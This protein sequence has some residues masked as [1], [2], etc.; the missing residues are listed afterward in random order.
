MKREMVK[1]Y[2]CLQ[3]YSFHLVTHS[4]LEYLDRYDIYQSMISKISKIS[5]F[6]STV[7]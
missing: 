7:K 6:S 4:G 3:K 5:Q 2:N 1:K